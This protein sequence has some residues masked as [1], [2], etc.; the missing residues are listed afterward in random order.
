MVD[1]KNHT[2]IDFHAQRSIWLDFE[3]AAPVVK[4]VLLELE[5]QSRY[6]GIH[7]GLC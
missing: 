1:A 2:S 7:I 3:G 6:P 4:C 5:I